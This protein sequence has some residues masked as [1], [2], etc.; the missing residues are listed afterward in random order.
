MI[1][2]ATEKTVKIVLTNKHIR[3]MLVILSNRGTNNVHGFPVVYVARDVIGSEA[4]EELA[5]M[6]Y[7]ACNGD[8]T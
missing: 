2:I 4:V 7:N 3:A 1:T 8:L 6:L 5:H